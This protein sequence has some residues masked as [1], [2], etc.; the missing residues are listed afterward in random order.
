[1]TSIDGHRR[2]AP[3]SG[4]PALVVVDDNESTRRI[5]A[6]SL[7]RRFRSDYEVVV[8]EST[9]AARSDLE[10]L[11]RAGADAALIMANEHL[12]TG[13][14]TDFLATTRGIYPTARRLVLAD[15][16]DNWVMPSNSACVHPGRGRP[17]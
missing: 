6:N 10:R 17:L 13:T 11:H 15:F 14:G 8:P 4:R 2:A 16:G 1:M 7:R 5:V 3:G 9:E 12:T